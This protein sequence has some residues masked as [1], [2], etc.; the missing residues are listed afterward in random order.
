MKSIYLKIVFV[1][2]A[3]IG[4]LVFFFA[5]PDTGFKVDDQRYQLAPIQ[6]SNGFEVADLSVLAGSGQAKYAWIP[7]DK[8]GGANHSYFCEARARCFIISSTS[9]GPQADR[10]A[11]YQA[12]LRQL[13]PESE[14][15]L[16]ENLHRNVGFRKVSEQEAQGVLAAYASGNAFGSG[17]G[18]SISAVVSLYLLFYFFAYRFA[19][20]IWFVFMSSVV[21]LS[22]II[23]VFAVFIQPSVL[24]NLAI[25]HVFVLGSLS[26]GV[27]AVALLWYLGQRSADGPSLERIHI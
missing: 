25:F 8:N 15:A 3:V 16:L 6:A 9:E 10:I 19:H 20:V 27:L 17:L 7:W 22:A 24:V 13:T 23:Y 12:N 14:D 4:G 11:I 21:A 5:F 2:W 1:A 26:F 18:F